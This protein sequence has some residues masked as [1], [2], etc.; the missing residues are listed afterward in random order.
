MSVPSRYYTQHVAV[1]APRIDASA[2]QP[3]WKI[4]TRLRIDRLLA[5]GAITIIEW[6]AAISFRD[7]VK[8]LAGGNRGYDRARGSG[9]SGSGVN[10]YAA[11][12]HVQNVRAMLGPLATALV[13]SC[14]IDDRSWAAVGVLFRIDPKTARRWTIAALQAL[15]AMRYAEVA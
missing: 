10:R 3:Y 5:D 13:W 9:S 15:A 6:R 14:V 1:E 2:F 7:A 12:R 11:L 8:L 4:V